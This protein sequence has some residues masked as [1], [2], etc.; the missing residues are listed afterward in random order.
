MDS[1]RE[2]PGC[3]VG[4]ELYLNETNG[5]HE[6]WSFDPSVCGHHR[7]KKSGKRKFAIVPTEKE[8]RELATIAD[9]LVVDLEK[10]TRQI[11]EQKFADFDRIASEKGVG[12][13]FTTTREDQRKECAAR[14]PETPRTS[15]PEE[16]PEGRIKTLVA[17]INALSA[18][19]PD[20]RFAVSSDGRAISA[21]RLL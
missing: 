2:L 7:A 18:K 10:D 1:Y 6:V 11:A 9:K 4:T 20:I 12:I 15:T 19:A 8:G 3:P 13:R 17:E 21:T 16:R 14:L 5:T